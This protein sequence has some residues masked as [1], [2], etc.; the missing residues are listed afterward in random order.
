MCDAAA[1]APRFFTQ[2]AAAKHLGVAHSAL[3]R[4]QHESTLYTPCA[5]TLTPGRNRISQRRVL[6]HAQQIVLI[7]AVWSG[8]M[9]EET[10]CIAWEV[11]RHR[12]KRSA[13]SDRDLG[14]IG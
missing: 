8:A 11:F 4:I 7:E 5:R 1:V 2:S 10:A 6:Y 3:S 12:L 9:D 14:A 13:L